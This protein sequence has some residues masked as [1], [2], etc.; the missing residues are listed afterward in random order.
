MDIQIKAATINDA[1]AFA[2]LFNTVEQYHREQ[3]PTRY[4]K[5]PVN[6]PVEFFNQALANENA[7]IFFATLE[8]EVLG[9]IFIL[10]KEVSNNPMLKSGKFFFVEQLATAPAA[11]RKNIG[12]KLMNF[13][14]K[15]AKDG[16]FE[17]VELNYWKFNNTAEKFYQKLG[18][19][20]KRVIVA[21]KV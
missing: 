8:N 3:I 7:K 12:S 14:E 4:E 2:K 10:V 17:E 15:L 18:Y 6:Y 9:Y 20:T 13:A 1:E 5:P 11:R 16:G 19:E 21:K